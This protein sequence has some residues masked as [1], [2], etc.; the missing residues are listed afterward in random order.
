M[1]PGST[2]KLVTAAADAADDAI[3]PSTVIP[4]GCSYTYDG[5]H[6]ANWECLP[7]QD[8]PEAIAWSNDVYFYQL[9]LALGPQRLAR[10]ATELGVGGLTGID[11]P[12]GEQSAGEFFYPGRM[13][14]GD[15]WYPGVTPM[16][17]IGQGYTAVTPLQDARWLDAVATGRLVTPH[18]GVAVAGGAGVTP[19]LHLAAA[20]LPFAAQ[21]A[22]VRAGLAL[23]VTQGT[24]TML[25][26][27]PEPAGGKTGT[28][29]DPSAPH[30]GPDA[31]YDAVYPVDDPQVVVLC[32]V[33]GGGQGY[34]DCEP[35]VDQLLQY[36]AANQA[37]IMSTKPPPPTGAP[38]P[39][40]PAS[41]SP[42]PTPGVAAGAARPSSPSP[43]PPVPPVAGETASGRSTRR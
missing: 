26:N 10:V 22:P 21:L 4:T 14:A 33:H 35:S 7:P 15:T 8:L 13:P 11:L 39:G 34:Y 41:S 18:L 30:G 20:A 31:W 16:M 29:Q 3:P 6:Y 38:A 36:F 32:A 1:P 12:L 9:A 42:A 23:E 28:A 27:L 5:I 43:A 37:G 19:L 24:G 17:G 25:R 2:F 40:R